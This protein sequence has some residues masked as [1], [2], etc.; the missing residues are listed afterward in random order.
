MA[1]TFHIWCLSW[2]DDEDDGCDVAG[3]DP[4]K[5]GWRD[6]TKKRGDTVW[7]PFREHILDV[8]EALIA[9]AR[10]CHNNRDGWEA[11][12]PLNFRVRLPDG[13]TEDYEVEREHVPEFSPHKLRV[14]S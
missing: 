3:Y 6:D 12:W 11:S 8:R 4:M 13:T 14:P 7:V 1:A 10:H 5:G 2:D 9:Y